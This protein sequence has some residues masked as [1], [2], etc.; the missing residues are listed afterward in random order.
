[1]TYVRI[2]QNCNGVTFSFVSHLFFFFFLVL[3]FDCFR[4]GGVLKPMWNYLFLGIF[5]LCGQFPEDFGQAQVQTIPYFIEIRRECFIV[6]RLMV[7]VFWGGLKLAGRS[8]QTS[9]KWWIL[10]IF[11]L[12]GLFAWVFGQVREWLIL[13]LHEM[14]GVSLVIVCPIAF[15][16]FCDLGQHG[17]VLK[18]MKSDQF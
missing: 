10:S 12:L 9:E 15:I 13:K 18:L 14:I 3:L 8:A 7:L 16:L 4:Q 11:S 2:A 5:N 1:M 17:G 6:V